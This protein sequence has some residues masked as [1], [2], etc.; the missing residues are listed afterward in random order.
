MSQTT[1]TIAAA[2]PRRDT[3]WK[4]GQSGNPLGRPKKP[5]PEKQAQDILKRLLHE[6]V[7]HRNGKPVS[8]FEAMALKTRN[9]VLESGSTIDLKRY[10]EMLERYS[11]VVPPPPSS[12]GQLL[13]GVLLVEPPC[14]DDEVWERLYGEPSRHVDWRGPKKHPGGASDSSGP[15]GTFG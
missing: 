6:T 10:L 7:A 2:D 3:K 1:K 15:A 11:A 4:R 12:D 13:T 14:V 8:A 9:T 5:P